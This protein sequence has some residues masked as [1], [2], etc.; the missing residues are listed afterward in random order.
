MQVQALEAGQAEAS[1]FDLSLSDQPARR[2]RDA[3][4]CE[5]RDDRDDGG[6]GKRNTPLDL[7]V[8]LLEETQVDPGLEEIAQ[9]DEASVQHNVFTTV[10]R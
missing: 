3:E 4:Y 5:H 6:N 10:S 2:F 7:E 1:F 9:G 8:V